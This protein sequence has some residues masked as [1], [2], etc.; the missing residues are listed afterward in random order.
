MKK[1]VFVARM[2]PPLLISKTTSC[3]NQAN[4]VV[5]RKAVWNAAYLIRVIS[6][7]LADFL[8]MHVSS[9]SQHM[10]SDCTVTFMPR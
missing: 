10:L 2:T 5:E 6:N 9:S 8:V 3:W 7:K 1:S 4:S